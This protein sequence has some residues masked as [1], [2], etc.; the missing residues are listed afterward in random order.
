MKTEN[1]KLIALNTQ[2]VEVVKTS[3]ALDVPLTI[4][5]EHGSKIK[6]YSNE[7]ASVS[8][9]FYNIKTLNEQSGDLPNFLLA[10][11]QIDS[12]TLNNVKCHADE[13]PF[14]ITNQQVLTTKH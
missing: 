12:N 13:S 1:E 5:L 2:L 6:I 10:I 14:T 3:L 4:A 7:I 8:E 9:R 11:S